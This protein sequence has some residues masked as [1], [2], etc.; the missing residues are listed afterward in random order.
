MGALAPGVAINVGCRTLVVC[1]AAFSVICANGTALCDCAQLQS[2]LKQ[3]ANNG[4]T[5]VGFVDAKLSDPSPPAAAGDVAAGALV[6]VAAAGTI[7]VL[8]TT[9]TTE[10]E[11]D[12]APPKAD[13][14]VVTMAATNVDADKVVSAIPRSIM[15]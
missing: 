9:E 10:D 2:A 11:G 6:V 15:S 5:H 4:P 3:F 8:G 1:V 14:V 13:E 12:A 7:D